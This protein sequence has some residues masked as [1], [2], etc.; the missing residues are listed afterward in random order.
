ML[1]STAA[2]LIAPKDDFTRPTY[3][4]HRTPAVR[5]FVGGSVVFGVG[6]YF[7]VRRERPGGVLA[8]A[9]IGSGVAMTLSGALLIAADEDE[10]DEG[11][12]RP[13]YRDTA[14]MGVVLGAAGLASTALGAVLLYRDR[15]V[16]VVPIATVAD[17]HV[18]LSLSGAF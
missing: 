14:A 16:P 18:L 3:D 9:A 5:V 13:T 6:A 11:Y 7:W 8:A 12:Q 4:D 15:S 1:A 10:H 17:H 2:Y